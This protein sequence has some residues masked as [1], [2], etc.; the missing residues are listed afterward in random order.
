M[1]WLNLLNWLKD[2]SLV[3]SA[4]LILLLLS[5]Y[6]LALA[7][8]KRKLPDKAERRMFYKQDEV[9]RRIGAMFSPAFMIVGLGYLRPDDKWFYFDLVTKIIL[10]SMWLCIAFLAFDC[11]RYSYRKINGPYLQLTRK[12]LQEAL[13][14][15]IE[16][17]SKREWWKFWKFKSSSTNP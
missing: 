12:E 9:N 1:N 5:L 16:E 8:V 7:Y 4:T 13:L 10:A 17:K 11:L 15:P 3:L 6:S 2:Y 14:Q